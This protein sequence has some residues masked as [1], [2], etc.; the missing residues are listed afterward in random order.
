[1][2]ETAKLKNSLRRIIGAKAALYTNGDEMKLIEEAV[3]AYVS[4]VPEGKCRCGGKTKLQFRDREMT[5]FADSEP[6][7]VSVKN[8]PVFVCE[9]CGEEYYS[10]KMDV[11]IEREIEEEILKH[12][13]ARKEPPVEYDFLGDFLNAR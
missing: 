13:R 8:A 4:D 5:V 6:T 10:L 1:M 11:L 9:S 7:A 2:L 3:R 12:L